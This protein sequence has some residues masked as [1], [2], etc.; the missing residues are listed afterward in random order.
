MEKN[1][2]QLA[3]DRVLV[4]RALSAHDGDAVVAAQRWVAMGWAA[5]GANNP[6]DAVRRFNQAFLID[7]TNPS[8]AYGLMIATHIR[9]DDFGVVD[10]LYDDAQASMPE[11]DVH[12]LHI[13]YAQIL[14]QR[15]ALTRAVE[16]LNPYRNEAGAAELLRHLN[17]LQEDAGQ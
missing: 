5:I 4:A 6:E 13:D 2:T 8:L 10:G 1:P 16:V 15:G 14:M 12:F 9:G 11:T 3:A 7:P 17:Q